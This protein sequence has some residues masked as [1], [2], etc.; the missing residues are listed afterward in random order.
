MR[1]GPIGAGAIV[2]IFLAGSLASAVESPRLG[3]ISGGEFYEQLLADAK[4]G[5]ARA[6]EQ[7]DAINAFMD[8]RGLRPDQL[9][10]PS[11]RR[12]TAPATHDV[13]RLSMED[14]GPFRLDIY[15]DTR[16][17]DV[18]QLAAYRAVR[19]AA[20]DALARRTPDRALLVAVTPDGGRS[21][22]ELAKKLP[23]RATGVRLIADIYSPAGWLMSSGYGIDGRRVSDEAPNIEIEVLDWAATAIGGYDGVTRENI[24]AEVRVLYARMNAAE[25]AELSDLAGVYAVDALTD[26]ADTFAGRAAIVEVA[27]APD[28]REAHARL[29]LGRSVDADIV[30]PALQEPS[31]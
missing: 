23:Q 6:V 8:E 28:L 9:T 2:G 16:F 15:N 4:S 25:A 7:L 20:L 26:I 24:H 1:L 19:H 14:N 29:V 21:V 17:E 13:I 18:H 27:N 31:K 11:G 10:L 3:P 12:S 30:S 5:N 22:A